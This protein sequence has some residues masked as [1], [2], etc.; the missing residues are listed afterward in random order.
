MILNGKI[1]IIRDYVKI[2]NLLINIMGV[3]LVLLA[4]LGFFGANSIKLA[5]KSES[6]TIWF[7]YNE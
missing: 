1:F 7:Y 4:L 5:H 2:Y 6:K 3:K